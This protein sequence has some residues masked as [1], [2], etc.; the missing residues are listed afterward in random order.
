MLPEYPAVLW[1]A[2]TDVE[3][4]DRL[5][6]IITSK[7]NFP[8]QLNEA[9]LAGHVVQAVLKNTSPHVELYTP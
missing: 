5:A 3:S 2:G 1:I 4:M 8:A 9:A 6:E 7:D